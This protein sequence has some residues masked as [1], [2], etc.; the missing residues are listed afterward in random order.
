MTTD[1]TI[2]A[3]FESGDVLDVIDVA[4]GQQKQL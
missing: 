3:P 1:L 2:E 4:M